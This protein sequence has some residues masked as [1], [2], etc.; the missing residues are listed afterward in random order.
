MGQKERTTSEMMW[1]VMLLG[2]QGQ[3]DWSA[4]GVPGSVVWRLAI[5]I[6]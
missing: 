3:H 6:D 5:R 4:V 2:S 1:I